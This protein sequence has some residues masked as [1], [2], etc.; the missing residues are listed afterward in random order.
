MHWVAKF[1]LRILGVRQNQDNLHYYVQATD[2]G[3][4]YVGFV[5]K[6][7]FPACFNE[8]Y[9]LIVQ[10]FIASFSFSVQ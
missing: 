7:I 5:G 4:T 10:V 6:N 9:A 1:L 2:F 8:S 3:D